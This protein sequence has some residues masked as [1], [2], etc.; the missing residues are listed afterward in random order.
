MSITLTAPETNA[1]H[2]ECTF[3]SHYHLQDSIYQSLTEQSNIFAAMSLVNEINILN[4]HQVVTSYT[5]SR[6]K[7]HF[8]QNG[9]EKDIGHFSWNG[10]SKNGFSKNKND[11]SQNGFENEKMKNEKTDT[12]KMKNENIEKEMRKGYMKM[13]SPRGNASVTNDQ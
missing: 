11:F 2:V 1:E 10:F 6:V 8:R 3:E 5:V 4:G 7:S 12:Q 9:T 13:M